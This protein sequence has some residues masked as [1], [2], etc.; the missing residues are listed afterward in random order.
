MKVKG[1]SE[2]NITGVVHGLTGKK[3]GPLRHLEACCGRESGLF[4]LVADEKPITCTKC[5]SVLPRD[6]NKDFSGR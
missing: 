3:T 6:I 5:L 4:W 2:N 1:R